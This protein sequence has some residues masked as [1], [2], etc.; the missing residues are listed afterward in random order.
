MMMV[1][2]AQAGDAPA[3]L[4]L[5]RSAG[6]G[7]TSF[8]PDL[9]M[10]E[11][12]IERSVQTLAGTLPLAQQGYLFVL[13][14][15]LDA[16]VAGVSGIEAAVGLDAPWYNYRIGRYL[17]TSRGVGV[18]S[19]ASALFL[20]NDHTGHSE[21]CT[22]FLA[23]EYRRDGNGALLSKARFM[24][25]A[26]FRERFT[27]TLVAEMRGVT[28]AR[29]RSPF[30]DAVCRP[31]FRMEF[32]EA[33][34]LVGLGR[35]SI[36]AELMPRHPLYMALLSRE[37]RAVVGEVH[38]QTAPA[39]ALLESEGL[40]FGDYVDIFDGGATLQGDID[41]LRIV[42]ESRRQSIDDVMAQPTQTLLI[43]NDALDAFRVTKAQV[44]ES[45]RAHRSALLETLN[46]AEMGAV[47]TVG[48][49]P[50]PAAC[51]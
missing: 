2:M 46:V 48:L 26:A 21:L 11:A 10:I 20:S 29:G 37:A 7:M 3:L 41:R 30:W 51:A 14:D 1:R 38:A 24:F 15:T 6:V 40:R 12:R 13:E 27:Q 33:D 16:R 42:R 5:A 49:R 22:L 36:I 8:M 45:M 32:A 17:H 44:G 34:R 25:I 39:R 4:A 28:D 19:D 31:F 47:R 35:K 23:P 18:S 9:A 50:A 43:A